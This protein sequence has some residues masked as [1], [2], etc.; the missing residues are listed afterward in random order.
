[1]AGGS[2]A[3]GLSNLL[4]V[5][6]RDPPDS[7]KRQT[8]ATTNEDN[9]QR[10]DLRW[11]L[12]LLPLPLLPAEQ[13]PDPESGRCDVR[14]ILHLRTGE[15]EGLESVADDEDPDLFRL[16]LQTPD[17][18]VLLLQVLVAGSGCRHCCWLQMKACMNLIRE[19]LMLSCRLLFLLPRLE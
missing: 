15:S 18:L 5:A 19:G 17:P 16:R 10:A 6:D 4:K 12:L 8:T 9:R 3:A 13:V 7:R 11:I 14:Q 1:M 2:T